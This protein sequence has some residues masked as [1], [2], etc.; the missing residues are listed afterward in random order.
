MQTEPTRDRLATRAAEAT[1]DTDRQANIRTYVGSMNRETHRAFNRRRG[2]PSSAGSDLRRDAM[3]TLHRTVERI[4][5]N[6][7]MAAG[8][9]FKRLPIYREALPCSRV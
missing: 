7:L 3:K 5:R 2:L 8:V 4:G 6:D 9:K 1:H